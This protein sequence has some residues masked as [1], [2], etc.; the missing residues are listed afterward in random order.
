[1]ILPIKTKKKGR[2]SKIINVY[3][4]DS[5]VKNC[6]GFGKIN[7]GEINIWNYEL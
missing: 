3:F 5:D 6:L 4:N 7:Y 1:M 2:D